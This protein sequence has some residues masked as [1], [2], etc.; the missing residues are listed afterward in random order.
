MGG[1]R[2]DPCYQS[3]VENQ[4]KA[5]GFVCEQPLDVLIKLI[6]GAKKEIALQA[7]SLNFPALLIEHR[8]VGRTSIKRAAVV[9]SIKA[10]LDRTHAACVQGK[11]G[12]ADH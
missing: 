2:I 3:E 5:V 1:R 11:G 7:H 12:A 6:C 10:E 9:S 4:K 8:Q